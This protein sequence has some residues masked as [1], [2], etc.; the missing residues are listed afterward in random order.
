MGSHFRLLKDAYR[1]YA[2]HIKR[3]YG[4]EQAK[5]I[6]HFSKAFMGALAKR[7]ME[8]KIV[9]VEIGE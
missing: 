2:M 1:N 7:L 9:E 8:S 3:V 6:F 5:D 4:R